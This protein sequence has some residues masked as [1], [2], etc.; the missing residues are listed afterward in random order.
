MVFDLGVLDPGLPVLCILTA[1]KCTLFIAKAKIECTL[2]KNEYSPELSTKS[3]N[4]L[5]SRYSI[6]SRPIQFNGL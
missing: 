2:H 6:F 1:A 3:C 5:S 4:K